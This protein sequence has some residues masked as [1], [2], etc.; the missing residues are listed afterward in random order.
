MER[1]IEDR[2]RAIVIPSGS[3]RDDLERAK[4]AIQYNKENKLYVPYI[5]SGI[6]PDTNIALGYETSDKEELDF[7]REL[8][9]YMMKNT[10][11]VIGL[12]VLSVNSIQNILNT[13][14]EGTTGTYAIVSYPLH[15]KRF[16]KI[17][18]KAREKG[19]I[20]DKVKIKYVPTK[21]SLKQVLYEIIP[22]IR[23]RKA[24]NNI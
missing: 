14:P 1:C 8:Y 13:F 5:I 2:V 22:A 12:D 4:R 9:G 20:S 24:I 17:F 7:H 10:Q 3:V 19:R 15:L 6:G 16:R 21:Q 23:R 11:G 18:Q